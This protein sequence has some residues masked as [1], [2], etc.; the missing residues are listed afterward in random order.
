MKIESYTDLVKTPDDNVQFLRHV[1]SLIDQ[2]P[3]DVPDG[4]QAL[5]S[6]MRS[7]IEVAGTQFSQ[8]RHL[9]ALERASDGWDVE[10]TTPEVLQEML[11]LSEK[12][13]RFDA[14]YAV[15]DF[16]I[17]YHWIKEL[18]SESGHEPSC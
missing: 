1:S 6:A 14:G 4:G 9:N 3:P 18:S 12:I 11:D 15:C 5:F 13:Q 2:L 8:A 10:N 17:G 16:T 7:G